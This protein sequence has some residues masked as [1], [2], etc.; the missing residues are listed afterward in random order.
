M[1]QVSFGC[2]DGFLLSNSATTLLAASDHGETT[3]W[4]LDSMVVLRIGERFGGELTLGLGI[5]LTRAGGEV[6][7]QSPLQVSN[8]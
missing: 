1:C 5:L 4:S 3:P 7:C 2:K 6:D 8:N